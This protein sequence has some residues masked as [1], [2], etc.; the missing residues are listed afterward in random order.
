MNN[1]KTLIN[2]KQITKIKQKLLQNISQEFL[3]NSKSII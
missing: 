1:L 3:I 2:I